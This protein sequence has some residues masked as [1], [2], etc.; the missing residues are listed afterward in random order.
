MWWR[1]RVKD[2]AVKRVCFLLHPGKRISAA[3][4]KVNSTNLTKKK[5]NEIT[6]IKDSSGFQI[7]IIPEPIC[8]PCALASHS[9]PEGRSAFIVQRLASSQL[10][11]SHVWTGQ[12]FWS[13]RRTCEQA[14]RAK[15]T[16]SV[17]KPLGTGVSSSE[18]VA[19]VPALD[20]SGRSNWT[21]DQKRWASLC[22]MAEQGRRLIKPFFFPSCLVL[23]GVRW[24]DLHVNM[25]WSVCAKWQ[26]AWWSEIKR[27]L[28]GHVLQTNIRCKWDRNTGEISQIGC[29]T[30]L[31]SEHFLCMT[32][33][34][35]RCQRQLF[36]FHLLTALTSEPMTR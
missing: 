17:R 29:L 13:P 11:Y 20:G 24:N 9:S 4:T 34:L 31:I 18:E 28:K 15:A 14:S 2:P 19:R 12:G 5:Q 22:L 32:K 35:V 6:D 25:R 21:K 23:C 3:D 33:V 36:F 10:V 30:R 8:A 26:W 1:G 7:L 27:W 16:E